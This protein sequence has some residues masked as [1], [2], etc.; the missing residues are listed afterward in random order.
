MK[1][2]LIVDD[3]EASITLLLSVLGD[4]YELSVALNGK[5]ALESLTEELPD[6]IVL[7]IV[8]DGINGIDL[9]KKLKQDHI[10]A[11]IP[12]MLLSATNNALSNKAKEVGADAL[13]G[14]PFKVNYFLSEIE[15]LLK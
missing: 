8:M 13:V 3:N 2:V 10:T 12:V 7:D 15:R 14:K 6:L 9:C 5:E 4:K 11:H 1:K